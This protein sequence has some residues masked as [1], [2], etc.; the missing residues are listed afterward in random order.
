MKIIFDSGIIAVIIVGITLYISLKSNKGIYTL[1]MNLLIASFLIIAISFILSPNSYIM[2]ISVISEIYFHPVTAL[3]TGFIAVGAVNAAGGF[4]L[5]SEIFIYLSRVKIINTEVFGI[6][7]IVI[8][9][10]N[11]PLILSLPCGRIIAALV[12]PVFYI[13][14][15][16]FPDHKLK[17]ETKY[18]LMI[19]LVLNAG[20]SCAP[21]LLGGISMIGA[22]FLG[23]DSNIYYYPQKIAIMVSTVLSVAITSK[24]LNITKIYRGEFP[25]DV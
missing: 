2:P 22:G 11:L 23:L 16:N 1:Q 15:E 24:I 25:E 20:A 12:L 18:A 5:L 14:L 13:I 6:P 4:K 21:S 9:V 19:G 3:I 8:I 7:G 17:P 10:L